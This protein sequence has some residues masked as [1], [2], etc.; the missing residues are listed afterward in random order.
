[1]FR[2]FRLFRYLSAS[3]SEQLRVDFLGLIRRALYR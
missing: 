2:Y 1:M 3:P